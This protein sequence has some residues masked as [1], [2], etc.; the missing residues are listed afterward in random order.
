MKRRRPCAIADDVGFAL[1]FRVR[2]VTIQPHQVRSEL[3]SFL[4]LL[5]EEKPRTVMEIGTAHG[6][7][8]FLFTRVAAPDALLVAVDL[9]EIGRAHV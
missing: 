3:E 9:A 7:T 4:G 8:L 2:S 6:G 5:A 1:T